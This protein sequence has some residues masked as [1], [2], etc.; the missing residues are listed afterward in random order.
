LTRK[1]KH[2]IDKFKF[3]QNKYT[4]THKSQQTTKERERDTRVS[5]HTNGGDDD[6]DD[7]DDDDLFFFFFFFSVI[8]DDVLDSKR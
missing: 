8:R 1:K 5:R 4:T 2:L 3:P 7:D 6:D